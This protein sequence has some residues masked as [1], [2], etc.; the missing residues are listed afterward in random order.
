MGSKYLK[1]TKN[2]QL[3]IGKTRDGLTQLAFKSFPKEK[4]VSKQ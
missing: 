3:I 4:M 2:N 1:G